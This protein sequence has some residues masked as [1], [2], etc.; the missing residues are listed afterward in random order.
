[1]IFQPAR[2]GQLIEVRRGDTQRVYYEQLTLGGTPINLTGQTASLVMYNTSTG[3]VTRRSGTV[4]SVASG[5]V[6]YQFVAE[7]LQNT[8][9]L[10]LEWELVNTA[11][12]ELT[13]PTSNYTK[14]NILPD[15]R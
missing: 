4:T 12:K 2:I 10:I 1:M 7:D 3:A 11:G 15:L 5:S 13:I 6:Q 9:S 8:G 14:L